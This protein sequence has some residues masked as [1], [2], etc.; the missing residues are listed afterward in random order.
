MSGPEDDLRIPS[1]AA[2]VWGLISGG[3]WVMAWLIW[4]LIGWLGS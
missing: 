1:G 4:R 2:I 3:C